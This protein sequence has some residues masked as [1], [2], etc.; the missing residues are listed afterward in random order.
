MS[1]LAGPFAMAV[2]RWVGCGIHVFASLFFSPAEMT[3]TDTIWKE[4]HLVRS[5]SCPCGP[6]LLYELSPSFTDPWG[7]W[8]QGAGYSSGSVEHDNDL[9]R[10]RPRRHQMFILILSPHIYI[11]DP[12]RNTRPTTWDA[13]CSNCSS[14]SS[15]FFGALR[16]YA[17]LDRPQ[18]GA[19][20]LAFRKTK[21]LERV[22][23]I[24][25]YPETM[26]N[27]GEI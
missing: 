15:P 22:K 24:E 12:E 3:S 4:H 10:L 11:L 16:R 5:E 26:R 14:R 19:Y 25:W 18:L 6:L 23:G 8:L 9:Y 21:A 7:T 27:L 20:F 2:T 13:K 17:I 1:D